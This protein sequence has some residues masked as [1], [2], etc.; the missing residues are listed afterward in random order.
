MAAQTG[1]KKRLNLA[2]QVVITL[3]LGLAAGL[4]FGDLT[5][6]LQGVG[7]AFILLL[8]MTVLPYIT[9]A[10]VALTIGALRA[11]FTMALDNAYDKDKII[12]SLQLMR[13]AGKATVYTTAPPPLPPSETPG[14]SRLARIRAW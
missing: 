3:A 1:Q 6:P 10:L 9:V 7:R 5:R 13:T 11:F 2:T 14:Q 8:Q 4:F 12:T